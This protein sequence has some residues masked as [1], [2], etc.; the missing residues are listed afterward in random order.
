M[1]IISASYELF[2]T[3]H[4][5]TKLSFYICNSFYSVTSCTCIR[6]W[7]KKIFVKDMMFSVI[8]NFP[9]ELGRKWAMLNKSY[10]VKCAE[11]T[12]ST[13]LNAI[14]KMKSR[15]TSGKIGR[16]HTPTQKGFLKKKFCH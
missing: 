5:I 3:L 4:L 12:N 9:V 2:H 11:I 1:Q 6:A 10:H 8:F 13:N 14:H 7:G 15:N 16:A